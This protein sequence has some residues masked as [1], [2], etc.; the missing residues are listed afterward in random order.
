MKKIIFFLLS[1]PGLGLA[2]LQIATTTT[3]LAAIVKRVGQ[4]QVDV[5]SIAKGTQ[6]PHHIEAKPS[7]M[8]K[9]RSVDI[10]IAHGLELESAWILPL[11]QGARNSKLT[12]K[13]RL[14]EVG[15]LLDPIEAVKGEVS[16]ADGDVHPG[17]N[18]HFQ[19]D[20]IRL[21]RAAQVIGKKMGEL[22]PSQ[23]E[24]FAKN[25]NEFDRE[26]NEKVRL[27]KTRLTKTGVTELVTY[28]KTF[29][30]FCERFGIRCAIH[31]EPKPG[32]P[33]T[34][35]HILSV[36]DQMK[37]RKLE[38]VFI[39]NLYDDSVGA[40]IRN[41]IPTALVKR[42]PVSVEGEP[43]IQTNEDLI[44]KLVKEIEVRSH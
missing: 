21:A 22:D 10:V 5:F 12:T 28:H 38:L 23:K 13:D 8:V 19:L 9:L 3:D 37:K 32:I 20:P 24:F 15:P 7:F 41:D 2:K 40:K 14:F 31:L 33:P 27:W 29:S 1:G 6:D 35:S 39:E 11:I 30:Y 26:L 16:R 4:G 36:I 43:G 34:A 44:E 18:P 42:V 17:G 25:A